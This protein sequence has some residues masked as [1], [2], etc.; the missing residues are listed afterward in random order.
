[1]TLVSPIIATSDGT[2][3]APATEVPVATFSVV[4]AG[5]TGG[6]DGAGGVGVARGEVIEAGVA[7]AGAVA[8]LLNRDAVGD[9]PFSRAVSAPI[10]TGT[11]TTNKATLKPCLNVRFFRHLGIRAGRWAVAGPRP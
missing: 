1:M 7:G 11:M 2:L 4:V 5:G 6:G 9:A 10:A 8:A 3:P